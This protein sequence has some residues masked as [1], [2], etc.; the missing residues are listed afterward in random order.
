M[1]EAIGKP[2]YNNA[3]RPIRV[4]RGAEPGE[5][6]GPGRAHARHRVIE[7]ARR[8]RSPP[9]PAR[10]RRGSSRRGPRRSV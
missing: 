7:A 4:T 8:W 6:R 1:D 10:C 2:E 9:R 5:L 3:P